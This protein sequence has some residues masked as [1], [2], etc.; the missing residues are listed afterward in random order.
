MTGFECDVEKPLRGV[1]VVGDQSVHPMG[2]RHDR[3][4]G[5]HPLACRPVQQVFAVQM[6]QVE[7]EHRQRLRFPGGGDVDAAIF[8]APTRPPP[9]PRRRHLKPVRTPVGPQGDC[10]R[11]GDQVGHRQL[12]RRLDHLR[13]PFGDVVEAASIDRHR[14]ARAVDLHARTV[15]LGLENRCAAEAFERLADTG[16]GLGQHRAHRLADL[17]RELDER[18]LAPGQRGGRDGGQV[19][20]QHCRAPHHRRGDVRGLRHR[21]GHHSDQ[22]TLPQLAA[23]QATEEGLLGLGG[24][25]EQSVDEFGAPRL[26]SLPGDLA[27]LAERA[28]DL[29]HRQRRRV[30][31]GRQ[32]AQRRPADPDLALRQFPGQPGHHDGDQLR[33]VLGACA[34]Q[35]IGDV[36]DLGQPRRSRA[37]LGRRGGDVNELHEPS[38]AWPSD[39][40]EKVVEQDRLC[41]KGWRRVRAATGADLVGSGQPLVDIGA[42]QSAD[43]IVGQVAPCHFRCVE[44]CVAQNLTPPLCWL[45]GH[46]TPA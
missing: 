17:E 40:S 11:V 36:G 39:I 26:R 15:Q 44:Q 29:Q 32:R 20:A 28:I 35:Q 38:L 19:A 8:P 3:V 31:R 1:G 37:D 10:L 13:Q 34:A 9:E 27:D 22:G 6:Q 24:C 18:R 2:R 33:V 23:E 45:N 42:Q 43:L 5:G 7:D 16:G 46:G 41:R 4:Q 30:R 25:G 21:V 12:E 14:V